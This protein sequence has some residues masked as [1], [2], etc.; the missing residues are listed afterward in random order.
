MDL[1]YIALMLKEYADEINNNEFDNL[2]ENFQMRSSIL[3]SYLL[4]AGIDPLQTLGWVPDDYAQGL[5]T[6]TEAHINDDVTLVG[7]SAFFKCNNLKSVYLPASIETISSFAFA[8]CFDLKEVHYGGTI[9]ELKQVSIGTYSFEEDVV[10]ICQ[11][12]HI[13]STA[14]ID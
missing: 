7:K 3:T 9:E 4:K 12:G 2:Y 11:A 10:C 13:Q 14:L 6:I 5:L 8:R 1:K